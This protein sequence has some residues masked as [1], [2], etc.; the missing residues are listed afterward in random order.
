VLK[1]ALVK[2]PEERYR[3]IVEAHHDLRNVK[4]SSHS[5]SLTAPIARHIAETTI[6]EFGATL[7]PQKAEKKPL[8]FVVAGITGYTEML[9]QLPLE[10]VNRF[11]SRAHQSAE[12]LA[13]RTRGVL[14]EFDPDR[15]IVLFGI[16][17]AQE[18]DFVTAINFA[19]DLQSLISSL[20]SEFGTAF[21]QLISLRCG[22]HSGLVLMQ[23]SLRMKS[24]FEITGQPFQI[25]LTLASNAKPSE[26]LIT[27]ESRRL[28]RNLFVSE[29]GDAL[30]IPGLSKFSNTY[31]LVKHSSESGP[32]DFLTPYTGRR[33][34]LS[35]LQASW[36][37]ALGGEGQFIAL[38]GEAGVGK[39]RLFTEFKS[40]VREN[41]RF[42][43]GQ[44]HPF[45][46]SI[47]YAPFRELLANAL[48]L[49]SSTST[50]EVIRK[51]HGLDPLLQDFTPLYLH[52]LSLQNERF[53]FP[54][55]LEGENL[56][57]AILDAL[58][59]FVLVKKNVPLLLLL[60]DWHWADDAS[61]NTLKQIL[62]MVSD[63]SVL[64]I[65][66][67]RP[68]SSVDW[69][70]VRHHQQIYL[71][72]LEASSS[73]EL[74]CAL[75]G[76]KQVSEGLA[77]LIHD[78]TGGNPFYVEEICFSL[79]EES[80]IKIDGETAVLNASAKS[81]RLP[82]T[83]QALLLSRLDRLDRNTKE[84]LQAAAVIGREFTRTILQ[85]VTRNDANLGSCLSSLKGVG[86]IQQMHVLPEA[87]YKFRH[88]LTQEVAYESMLTHEKK[89]I[90]QH[91]AESIEEIYKQ[92]LE[93]HLDLLAEH[94]S[95]A[96]IWEKAVDY[97]MRS[98]RKAVALGQFSE[99]L[100]ILKKAEQWLA[101]MPS[102]ASRQQLEI[103]LML[104]EERLCETLGIR[105]RQEQILQDLLAA[106][107]KA[108]DKSREME[109]HRRQG[110]LMTLLAR[111]NAA[112]EALNR[113]LE[114]SRLLGDRAGERNALRSIG[115][116]RWHQGKMMKP[117]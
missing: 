33:N 90:H 7:T 13:T 37:K 54:K 49:H 14:N 76:C 105:D 107:K 81:L 10:E 51:I 38:M 85:R 52:L 2:N 64:A 108:D 55:H 45:G 106:L 30:T 95:R 56:R 19:F 40:T 26:V 88:A 112:E 82:E 98:S 93:E 111:F 24:K 61:Q 96:A 32:S 78:R 68:D 66:T 20:A 16:P 69:S 103:D 11:L 18:N 23:P 104:Q 47:P 41:V 12:D 86:L 101:G 5:L 57:L 31:S 21:E 6:P 116:M 36:E 58:T 72:P 60:E 44:C 1:K 89:Q 4:L 62:E 87:T 29:S 53:P 42:L 17:A 63:Q 80:K 94:Y 71:D 34:E 109:V 113:S 100:Q 48:E 9:E 28:T 70:G 115:F 43:R 22:V 73:R 75:L 114:L 35:A 74:M 15:I 83:I 67:Y 65:V 97:G 92:R 39:S 102:D 27:Q 59:A 3:T 79:Q 91:V 46:A 110:E 84:V 8:T 99:A 50:E 77:Q 117:Y 25:A